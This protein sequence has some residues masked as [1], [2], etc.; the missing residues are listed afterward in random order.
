MAIVQGGIRQCGDS[1]YPGIFVRLDELEILNFINSTVSSYESD[2]GK[3]IMIP[4][5]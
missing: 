3:Q 1:E 2:E 4:Y 5:D